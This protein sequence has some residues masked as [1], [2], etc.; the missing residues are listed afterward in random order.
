MKSKTKAKPNH[1]LHTL[2][3]TLY[4]ITN[5]TITESSVEINNIAQQNTHKNSQQQYLR[6]AEKN[7]KNNQNNE[8]HKN[9]NHFHKTEKQQ[10]KQNHKLLA[11]GSYTQNHFTKQTQQLISLPIS[12][13]KQLISKKPIRF[14]QSFY[15]WLK[16][17]EQELSFV[18]D[19]GSAN[20]IV[21]SLDSGNEN[22]AK[23]TRNI[24]D[25]VKSPLQDLQPKCSD[26]RFYSTNKSEKGDYIKSNGQIYDKEKDKEISVAHVQFST[27]FIK[28]NLARDDVCI[29][30]NVC[31]S[32]DF[33]TMK[34]IKN[35][36]WMSK[37]FDGVLGLGLVAQSINTNYSFVNNFKI[38]V[39]SLFLNHEDDSELVLGGYRKELVKNDLEFVDM[40]RLEMGHY[41]A[42]ILSVFVGE[43]RLPICNTFF[44]EEMLGENDVNDR[45]LLEDTPENQ[46]NLNEDNNDECYAFFDSGATT[47]AGSNQVSQILKNVIDQNLVGVNDNDFCEVVD[48]DN[49]S[50]DL[51]ITFILEHNVKIKF[52]PKQY[53]RSLYNSKTKTNQCTSRILP[54]GKSLPKEYKNVFVLGAPLFENYLVA[55]DLEG[56]KIGVGEHV[57]SEL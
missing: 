49:F 10:I 21:P 29:I 24:H 41:Q 20:L 6:S 9:Q 34:E 28:S 26:F 56:G 15:T 55:F 42:K 40:V 54:L 57:Y 27:A 48:K 17:G 37:Q 50:Q 19:T 35:F 30:D 5:F 11:T 51:Q 1:I 16:I 46:R 31:R 8:N 38:P 13:Q 36:D 47:L 18:V 14:K 52:T 33:L 44:E 32:M 25:G 22:Y 53:T 23:C 3:F 4:L 45:N 43:V 7:F 39:F 2:L 12:S